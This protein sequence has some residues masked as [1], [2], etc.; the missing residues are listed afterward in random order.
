MVLKLKIISL[1]YEKR[2]KQTKEIQNKKLKY[3][4]SPSKSPGVDGIVPKML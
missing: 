3:L 1:M 4:P 2:K